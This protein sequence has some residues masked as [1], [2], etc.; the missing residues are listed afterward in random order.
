MDNKQKKTKNAFVG[1]ILLF[2][3]VL[4]LGMILG[5][6]LPARPTI[7]EREKRRLAEFPEFSVEGMLNGDYFQDISSWYADTYPLRETW[8]SANREMKSLYGIQ[9]KQILVNNE[10]KADAIP[11]IPKQESSGSAGTSKSDSTVPDTSNSSRVDNSAA[12]SSKTGDNSSRDTAQ[13]SSKQAEVSRQ[14]TSVTE[15][16]KTET[17]AKPE[18]PDAPKE[19][20][21]DIEAQIQSSLYVD[22]NA[23]YSIYYFTQEEADAYIAMVND[24]AKRLE[25][26]ANF[27][28]IIVPDSTWVVLDDDK[29]TSLGGSNEVQAIQYYNGMLEEPAH[30]IETI[31]TLR[32]HKGDYMYYRT[33]HHWTS[34]GAYY[35]YCNY[36]R[37]KGWT[38]HALTDFT[39]MDFGRFLGTYYDNVEADAMYQDPDDVVAYIPMGTNDIRFFA[40]EDNTWWDW[41]VIQDVTDW[42]VYGKY[43][44]F[45]GGDNPFSII[46]NPQITDG[47]SCVLIKESYGNAF[48]PFLVDHYQTTYVIDYRYYDQS[49]YD[50]IIENG[51]QD[52][53]LMNNIAIAGSDYVV[54]RLASLFS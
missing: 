20:A 14:D 36:A 10:K 53:I 34:L 29:T 7:S 1:T 30:F 42:A 25:G 9:T 51:V 15:S 4:T 44:T 11:V 19:M 18:I 13:D 48:A 24:T 46:E 32:S 39:R 40:E 28:N 17:S 37:A 31:E 49:I 5:M 27:Y 41:K 54:N 26:T 23:A 45:I 50:F 8:L 47:S 12:E 43:N 22:G 52:V 6:I 16:S 35:I 2:V 38:P 3:G 21:A 33:D